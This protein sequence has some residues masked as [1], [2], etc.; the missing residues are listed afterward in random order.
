[1]MTAFAHTPHIQ[2]PEDFLALFDRHGG[3]DGNYLDDHYQRFMATLGEFKATWT[4]PGGKVL[5]VGAHWLH[6]AVMWRQTGFELVAV[7]LPMTFQDPRIR[8]VAD[9]MDI[10][11]LSC[12]DLER[13]SELAQIPDDSVDVVLFTEILEHITFN[14]IGFWQQIHRVLKPMGRI[15]VTTPNYYSWKGRAWQPWR[16]LSGRGGGI[17]V[18]EVLG[19]HT[20][21]HHWREY[22]VREVAR[23]FGLLSPDFTT[24]KL[25]LMP[26]YRLSDVR[27]KRLAQ[28][29]LDLC[30]LLRPNIHAEIQLTS[31]QAGIV[32]TPHW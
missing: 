29:T 28:R 5:D 12:A 15:V 20:Y 1:M 25:R 7:D 26:T 23:Y 21:A 9:H 31:K 11:L 4:Q 18:D 14:P 3:T 13:A 2:R 17:S 10:S 16:F 27:W 30:P 22:S 32:A 8:S 24:V 19:K 6:Q